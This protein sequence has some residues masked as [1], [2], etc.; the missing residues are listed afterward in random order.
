MQFGA[1]LSRLLL[2]LRIVGIGPDQLPQVA[3]AHRI[4][5]DLRAAGEL[6]QVERVA[7]EDARC[8]DRAA[9]SSCRW[10]L[11][12]SRTR[13]L[14]LSFFR[15]SPCSA[16]MVTRS[17]GSRRSSSRM[18]TS[19][20]L[21][22]RSRMW[23]ASPRS[24]AM[25]RPGCTMLVTRSVRTSVS[26]RAQ[27]AQALGRDIGADRRKQQR[28]DDRDRQERLK[29]SPRPHAGAVHHD[30]FGIGAELVQDVRNRHHQRDRRDHQD[31]QR[32]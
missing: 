19:R 12:F 17:F 26:Q 30:D 1:E 7:V 23:K 2:E 27:H 22:R 29:Q 9:C 13:K 10:M 24:I 6:R 8:S 16:R 25:K 5:D 14:P 20:P 4:L 11:P 32:E 3:L 18:P 15:I 31:Q 21:G 28:H